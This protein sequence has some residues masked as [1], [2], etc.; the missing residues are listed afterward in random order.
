MTTF[1]LLDKREIDLINRKSFRYPLTIA[2]KD[3]MLTIVSKIVFDSPLRDKLIFKGGTAI[4]HCYLPQYRFSEDLDFTAVDKTISLSEVQTVLESNDFMKVKKSYTSRATI[5][6]ERLLYSGPLVHPNSLKFEI[7]F[8]QNVV[9]PPQQTAYNNIWGVKTDVMAMDI[10]E[11]CA[12][13]IRATSDRARYRDFYDLYLILGKFRFE[14]EDILRLVRQKEIRKTISR[15]SINSN[16]QIA[17]QENENETASIYYT[18]EVPDEAIE[19]MI[20][21]LGFDEI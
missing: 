18:R 11:V 10:R 4:H 14:M 21:N 2:E 5:K 15:T 8:I 16:W 17:K 9:L 20:K 19:A 13:K 12:E 6:I 7:D 3:Y 1:N